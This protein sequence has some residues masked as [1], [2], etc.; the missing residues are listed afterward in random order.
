M[1]YLVDFYRRLIT[2]TNSLAKTS[3]HGYPILGLSVLIDRTTYQ[4]TDE[5]FTA[6]SG[7]YFLFSYCLS[8]M[9]FFP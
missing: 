5:S 9:H 2:P 1:Y 4:L 8:S 7:S 3:A 6:S